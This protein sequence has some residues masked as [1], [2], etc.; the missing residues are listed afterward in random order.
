[1]HTTVNVTSYGP[2][3]PIKCSQ[4]IVFSL[5]VITHYL[6]LFFCLFFDKNASFIFIYFFVLFRE[7]ARNRRAHLISMNAVSFLNLSFLSAVSRRQK[8]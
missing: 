1:M 7:E 4:W 3:G 6:V 5:Q 2:I 8:K